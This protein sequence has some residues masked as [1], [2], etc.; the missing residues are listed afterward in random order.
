[1]LLLDASRRAVIMP[2]G[3]VTIYNLQGH[4]SRDTQ[5]IHNDQ[6][7]QQ[8]HQQQQRIRKYEPN[9]MQLN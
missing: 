5:A 6:Q 2:L 3:L 4:G 1:M 7:Q 9:F 8:Q